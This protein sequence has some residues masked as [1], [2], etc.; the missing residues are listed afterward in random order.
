MASR[1]P[2]STRTATL[3]V[4]VC[5]ERAQRRLHRVGAA[6]EVVAERRQLQQRAV[7]R[8]QRAEQRVYAAERPGAH[9]VGGI[10]T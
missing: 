4:L 6:V 3:T 1:G 8:A 10:S 7:E 2:T 5:G 9:I